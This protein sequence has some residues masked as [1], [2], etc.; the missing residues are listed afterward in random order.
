MVSRSVAMVD[1]AMAL[2]TFHHCNLGSFM[3]ALVR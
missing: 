3:S 2:F 1:V